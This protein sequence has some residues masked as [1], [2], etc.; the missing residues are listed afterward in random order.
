MVL[1]SPGS[2]VENVSDRGRRI[3]HQRRPGLPYVQIAV[4]IAGESGQDDGDS[5]GCEADMEP[6]IT[7]SATLRIVSRRSIDVF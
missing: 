2:S 5:V 3:R 7:A 1:V 4:P 6:S